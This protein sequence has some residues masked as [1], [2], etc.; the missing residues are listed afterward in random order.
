MVIKHCNVVC[1]CC[2]ISSKHCF[3]CETSQRSQKEVLSKIYFNIFES[4]H[5]AFI[6]AHSGQN[7]Q[8]IDDDNLG[9]AP[10]IWN[11][12]MKMTIILIGI[13]IA[14]ILLTIPHRILVVYSTINNYR[15]AELP[16][17]IT[18]QFCHI[19]FSCNSIFYF[20]LSS[21][22]REELKTTCNC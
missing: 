19:N 2:D 13:S 10:M 5:T 3:D 14:F 17:A 11:I 21:E 8:D 9:C 20:F 1:F 12:D 6:R 7:N 16:V 4:N 18:R 15:I 22:C